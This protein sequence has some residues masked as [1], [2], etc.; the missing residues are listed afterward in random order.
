M[1]RSHR[2]RGFTLIEFSVVITVS[3]LLLAGAVDLYRTYMINDRY[4]ST[5]SEL[6]VVYSSINNYSAATGR[7]PFP[8]D[9]TLP[10]SSANAGCEC[11]SCSDTA[12]ACKALVQMPFGC[13]ASGGICKTPGSHS[14][15]VNPHPAEGN[16]PVYTGAVPYKTIRNSLSFNSIALGDT[17]DPW[18]Y[19]LGYAV[20]SA[21]TNPMIS[22]Q[23]IYGVIDVT[24][25]N[26]VELTTPAG[27]VNFIIISYGDNHMGAYTAEGKIGKPCIAG[28]MDAEN[29]NG[30]YKFISGLRSLGSG[31]AY[32]DDIVQYSQPTIPGLWGFTAAGSNNIHNLNAGNVGIGVPQVKSP[33]QALEVDGTVNVANGSIY[34]SGICDPAGANCWKPNL[35]AGPVSGQNPSGNGCLPAPPGY[36][37]VVTGLTNGKVVCKPFPRVSAFQSQSCPQGHFAVGFSATSGLICN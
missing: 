6:N 10:A 2:R 28:T 13:T 36:M 23:G 4:R 35:L 30:D 32:F 19:Q 24:T 8:A 25:E 15:P 7:L 17:L 29:C 12:A 33:A 1:R 16:D 22:R 21:S 37:N 27:S 3:G 34:A 20:S 9:P 18:N 5:V 11:G 26:G 31:P 14:T